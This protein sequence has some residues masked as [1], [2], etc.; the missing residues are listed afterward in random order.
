MAKLPKQKKLEKLLRKIE[1]K[2]EQ[3]YSGVYVQLLEECFKRD[4]F[5]RRRKDRNLNFVVA[6]TSNLWTNLSAKWKVCFLFILFLDL[7]FT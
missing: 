2:C 7:T 5:S 1:D 6:T 4:T 3:T